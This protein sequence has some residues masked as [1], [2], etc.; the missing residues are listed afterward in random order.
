MAL[1]PLIRC[2]L[3]YALGATPK[4]LAVV[5]V[6]RETQVGRCQCRTVGVVA[7]ALIQLED[8]ERD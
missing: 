4:V 5:F 2:E 6:E 7:D 8:V 1:A 3:F